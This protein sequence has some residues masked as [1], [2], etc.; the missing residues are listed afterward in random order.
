MA[1]SQIT[2]SRIL[3]LDV[4]VSWQECVAIVGE[5]TTLRLAGPALGQPHPRIDAESC[6][7]TRRGDELLPDPAEAEQP[8]ADVQLLRALLAGRE[9]PADLE[10]VAYGPPPTHLGDALAMF[11]R[12]DRRADIAAVAVRGLAADV[13]LQ[14]AVSSLSPA[15]PPPAAAAAPDAP[16]DDIAQLRAQVGQRPATP[17]APEPP[18][19]STGRVSRFWNIR[20]AVAAVVAVSAIAVGYWVTSRLSMPPAPE[21]A[22]PEAL[23]PAELNDWWH[24]VGSREADIELGRARAPRRTPSAVDGAPTVTT[25]GRASSAKRDATAT[26]ALPVPAAPAEPSAATRP[27]ALADPSPAAVSADAPVYSRRSAGVEPPVMM[28]PRMPESAF[29]ASDE[30]IDGHYLE[31]LVD[32]SGGVE[33]VRLRGLAGPGEHSYSTA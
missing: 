11:S 29:P 16:A 17:P 24:V 3:E 28:Y 10:Q 20:A 25:D 12:P 5:V 21:Q 8:D 31:V 32:Q 22:Q 2:V 30:A 19:R 26:V 15:V 9:M 13:E 6:V 23:L 1:S 18:S 7:L 27:G 14:R 33:A 4:P